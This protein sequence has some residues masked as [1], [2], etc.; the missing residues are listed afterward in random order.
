MSSGLVDTPIR[1]SSR[2]L[3]RNNLPPAG[4]VNQT[5]TVT[6][7]LLLETK[8]CAMDSFTDFLAGRSNKLLR[9]FLGTGL[10]IIIVCMGAMVMINVAV[11][12]Y[13]SARSQSLPPR[14]A[15][16]QTR[17]DG[18][19]TTITRSV[20]D[21]PVVTGSTTSRNSKEKK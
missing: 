19:V 5:L 10:A 12:S 2:A 9:D 16:G 1:S 13:T 17:P 18:P 7:Y 6:G 20:L 8:G 11:D 14:L 3:C 21:D 15:A 4:I